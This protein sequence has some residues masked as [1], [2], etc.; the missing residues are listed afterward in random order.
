VD[1]H[2]AARAA[3]LADEHAIARADFGTASKSRSRRAQRATGDDG[4]EMLPLRKKKS[5]RR[6]PPPNAPPAPPAPP[7]TL[8]RSS[9]SRRRNDRNAIDSPTAPALTITDDLQYAKWGDLD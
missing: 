3:E 9:S 2:T 5:S 8:A 4:A 7:A 1:E 6:A